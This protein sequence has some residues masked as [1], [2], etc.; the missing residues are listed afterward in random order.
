MFKKKYDKHYFTIS[1]LST[2]AIPFPNKIKN[3]NCECVKETTTRTKV[4][5]QPKATNGAPGDVLHLALNE[6]VY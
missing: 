5:Q 2:H 1:F 3:G 6:N 4:R